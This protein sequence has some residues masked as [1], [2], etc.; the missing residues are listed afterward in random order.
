M[1]R[2]HRCGRC[3]PGS[4]PGKGVPSS[5]SG[6]AADS[7]SAPIGHPGSTPGEG[8]RKNLKAVG[9]LIYYSRVENENKKFR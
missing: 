8:V 6:S 4:S 1:D 2:T 3:D 9:N 7:N 5:H